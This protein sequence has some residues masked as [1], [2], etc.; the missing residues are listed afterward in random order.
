M[1]RLASC[2]AAALMLLAAGCDRRS[3]AEATQEVPK[4]DP[5]TVTVVDVA[6]RPVERTVSVVGTLAASEQADRASEIEGQVVAILADLGDRVTRDQILARVRDDV[7]AAKLREAEATLEKATADDTRA[8]PLRAQGIISEQEYAQ[9]KWA[10]ETARAHRDQLKIDFEHAAIRSPIDGSV[11]ARVVNVGDY[12]RPG[13]VVFKLVQDDP[14]KFR[15][16]I[17]ERDVPS[18]Q[19]GQDIRVVVDA[20]PGETFTGRVSRVG[21]ASDP[22]ARSLTFEA[23]MPNPDHRIRPGFFGHGDIVTRRDDHAVAVPRSALNTFAGVTKLF[24][25][26]D[27]VAHEH[28]VSLGVDLGDG[29]VEIAQGVSRGAQVA[30]SG[31]SRLADGTQVVVRGDA[32]PGA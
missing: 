29:W 16:E 27:G 24:V 1:T 21:S 6:V 5:V 12:V 26:E 3:G 2:A 19:P 9:V 22:Q 32:P 14:L 31:L 20:F 28:E 13:T 17:P 30:T 7:L 23:L 10:I 15:G 4:P 11:A 8:R 18:V 25:I